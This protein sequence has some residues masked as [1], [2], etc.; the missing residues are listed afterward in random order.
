MAEVDKE[1][2]LEKWNKRRRIVLLIFV[3]LFFSSDFIFYYFHKD[4]FGLAG[5]LILSAIGIIAIDWLFRLKKKRI[6]GEKP[7]K[8][9]FSNKRKAGVFFIFAWFFYMITIIGLFSPSPNI[10]FILG[11]FLI[12][13]LFTIIGVYILKK[14]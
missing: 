10:P 2:E 8:V 4:V 11:F 13:V 1:K 14:R 9:T 12:G 7:K 3:I 6:M 5:D